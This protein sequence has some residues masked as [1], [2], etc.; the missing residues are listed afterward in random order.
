MFV[1]QYL[2][3]GL[4][5]WYS[6]QWDGDLFVHQDKHPGWSG[7]G[8]CNVWGDAETTGFTQPWAG[9]GELLVLPATVEKTGPDSFFRCI[10]IG[11]AKYTN[12]NMGNSNYM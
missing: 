8:A 12:W 6:L 1:E 5:P 9:E 3:E 7:T 4:S 2:T 10:G 11:E